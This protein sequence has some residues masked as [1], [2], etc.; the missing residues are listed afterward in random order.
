MRISLRPLAAAVAALAITAGLTPAAVSAATPETQHWYGTVT[1]VNDGDTVYVDIQGDS[2]G[3]VPIRNLG[4]QATEKGGGP[5]GGPE[6][7]ATEATAR[8]TA[9]LP[10]GTK[11]RLSA[12]HASSTSGTDPAGATRL[13]RYI[14][15]YNPTTGRYDIDVQADLL[16]RGLVMW[17]GHPIEHER[18]SA[19]HVP[20]QQA[21]KARIGMFKLHHCGLGPAVGAALQMWVHYDADNDF[22]ANSERLYIRNVGASD[23]SLAGWRLRDQSH[24]FAGPG[25]MYW[26]FPSAATVKAGQYIVIHPGAGTNDVTRGRYFLNVRDTH[27]F[28]NVADNTNGYPGRSVFLLDPHLDFRGWANYPCLVSCS[29]PPLEIANV[30]YTTADEYVDLRLASTA[31]RPVDLTGVTVVN[32]GWTKEI[33]PGTRLNPG[34]T[35]RVYC[36]RTG[37]D[38]RLTQYWAP[39]SGTMLEDAGDTVRIRTAQS[40]VLDTYAWGN[41]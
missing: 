10:R 1:A 23:V 34:E 19:L 21:M 41:G 36:D 20:M 39:H 3:A 32:D 18:A 29:R 8:M 26:Y 30:R 24:T 17:G 40:V 6:C 11:V 37:Q 27:F 13:L 5:N 33:A 2:L 16:S 14:D 22:V 7:H 4:I 25:R 31:T 12:Y 15:K 35:L 28:P 38:T 9:L